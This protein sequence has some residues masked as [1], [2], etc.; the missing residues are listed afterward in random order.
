MKGSNKKKNEK[1]FNYHN[2]DRYYMIEEDCDSLAANITIYGRNDTALELSLDLLRQLQVNSSLVFPLWD[3]TTIYSSFM[4]SAMYGDSYDLHEAPTPS[5]PPLPPTEGI[6]PIDMDLKP[7]I[8]AGASILGVVTL[9]VLWQLIK[10]SWL[11]S[12]KKFTPINSNRL[13]HK[14]D[15]QLKQ[16]KIKEAMEE[17]E[18]VSGMSK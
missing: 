9:C 4:L 14:T 3:G 13:D 16:L 5:P 10:Q 6:P 12:K 2:T 1:Q 18:R 17:N 7:M 11:L 15:Q 8:Y